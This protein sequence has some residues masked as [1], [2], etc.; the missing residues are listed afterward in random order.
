MLTSILTAQS[1]QEAN[2]VKKENELEYMIETA[3]YC[4]LECLKKGDVLSEAEKECTRI[5]AQKS[6]VASKIMFTN[7][8]AQLNK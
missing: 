1:K 3:G 4:A 2:L 5:C 6:F 7:L 8:A